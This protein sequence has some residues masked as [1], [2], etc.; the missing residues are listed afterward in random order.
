MWGA[1]LAWSVPYC[2]YFGYL[3]PDE[4]VDSSNISLVMGIPSWAFWGIAAPW[5]A[6]DVFTTWFCFWYMK[7]DDL[8]EA[9]EGLDL[10]EEIAEMH[11][12][13]QKH[14]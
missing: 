13:D 11:A 5:L 9:H 14:V 3:G 8:G 7:D 1:C 10:E 4:T 6:A 2:Y 12:G